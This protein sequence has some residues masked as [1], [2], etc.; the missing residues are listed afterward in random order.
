MDAAAP[1]KMHPNKEAFIEGVD[2][3]LA[4]W[5]AL[6]LAIE[7]SWGGHE[8]EEKRDDMVDDI[9]EF[10]D[11]AKQKPEPLDLQDLLL[12][13]MNL[14]FH[15]ELKDESEKE[16]AA[17]LCKLFAECRAGNFTTVDK[18]AAERDAREALGQGN[19]A[20]KMSQAAPRPAG[21]EVEDSDSD[22]GS[23]CEDDSDD[24][25]EED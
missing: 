24:D 8:T 16:V 18:L 20:V 14:D 15:V 3:I 9:V 10:F 4:K 12:E 1:R 5:T 6:G 7:H 17:V 25:M 23:E 13:I 11:N 22:S 2:H 21:M 19:A